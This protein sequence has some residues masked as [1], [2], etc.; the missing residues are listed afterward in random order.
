MPEKNDNLWNN[1]FQICKYWIKKI[2]PI[3]DLIVAESES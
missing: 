1:H 2:N 3:F